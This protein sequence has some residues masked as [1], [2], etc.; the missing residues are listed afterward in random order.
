[1]FPIKFISDFHLPK[2]IGS[3]LVLEDMARIWPASVLAHKAR[4]QGVPFPFYFCS[5]AL[6]NPDGMHR[7]NPSLCLSECLVP[8]KGQ[9]MV[10]EGAS[11]HTHII[12]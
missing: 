11:L 12:V 10:R 9:D 7:P 3:H 4:L 5:G 2:D 8:E 6:Q 1:M